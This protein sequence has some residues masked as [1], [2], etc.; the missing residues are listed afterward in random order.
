MVHPACKIGFAVVVC[1][2]LLTP[3]AMWGQ[4]EGKDLPRQVRDEAKLFSEKA[5]EDAN[6]VIAKIKEKHRKDFLIET[7]EKLPEDE[8]PAKWA[9]KRAED[10]GIDGVYIVITTQP[11]HLEVFV[12]AKTRESG[13]LV[14]AD[15]DEIVTTLRTNL[16]KKSDEALLKVVNLTLDAMNRRA[17]PAV[18]VETPGKTPFNALVGEWIGPAIE[19]TLKSANEFDDT[20]PRK[21]KAK[22]TLRFSEIGKKTYFDLGYRYRSEEGDS[23]GVF[24]NHVFEL[25]NKE[26]EITISHAKKNVVLTFETTG[27]KLRI[28]AS[29]KLPVPDGV[30]PVDVSGEWLRLDDSR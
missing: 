20:P 21:I 16:G 5:T 12:S 13:L 7:M 15:R 11:K 28:K 9:Q 3:N 4:K 30:A 17:K 6:A 1:G 24:R 19:V 18:V 29:G 10:A 23:V 26:R 2:L 8:K 25:N 27:Q 14:I 22:L